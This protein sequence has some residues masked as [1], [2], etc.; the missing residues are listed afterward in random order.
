[1]PPLP[2]GSQRNR[3]PPRRDDEEEIVDTPT[4]RAAQKKK[5]KEENDKQRPR[6]VMEYS[7][8]GASRNNNTAN[9]ISSYG[10]FADRTHPH[11]H[12]VRNVTLSTTK[13]LNWMELLE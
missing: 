11:I 4:D 3:K 12:Q 13:K 7:F 2:E 10:V 8:D 6:D 5:R 9:V 1:V